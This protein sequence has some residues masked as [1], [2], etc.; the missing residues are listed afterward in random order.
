MRAPNVGMLDLTLMVL[1]SQVVNEIPFDGNP[2]I[3]AA[4]V[5]SE[6]NGFTTLRLETNAGYRLVT[7]KRFRLG[8]QVGT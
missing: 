3:L 1:C 4:S 8:E 5:L 6:E 2:T 7:A